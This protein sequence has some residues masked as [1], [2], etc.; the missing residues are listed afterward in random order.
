MKEKNIK[1]L[2]KEQ[3]NLIETPNVLSNIKNELGIDDEQIMSIPSNRK[4]YKTKL[5]LSFSMIIVFI[6]SIGV[7][8]L[9]TSDPMNDDRIVEALVVSSIASTEIVNQSVESLSDSKIFQVADQSLLSQTAEDDIKYEA[10]Y[11]T[12]YINMM[13]TL[14]DTK[15]NFSIEKSRTSTFSN[16]YMLSFSEDN[17]SEDNKNYQLIYETMSKSKQVY[18]VEGI[19]SYDSETYQ[20]KIIYDKSNQSLSYETYKDEQNYIRVTFGKQSEYAIYEVSRVVNDEVTESIEVKYKNRLNITLSFTKGEA[21]G[22]YS[23]EL[24]T[25]MFGR[26]YLDVSYSVNQYQG[27]MQIAVSLENRDEFVFVVTPEDGET[28]TF[29]QQRNRFGK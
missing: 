12:T 6:I 20:V 10:N 28:F 9:R 24:K 25:S 16:Q 21:H 7:V 29:N 1:K 18:T 26:K 19:L 17:L 8:R 13:A 3:A 11:L 22:S 15:Q 23:F 2:I 14:T 5:T 27:T 4:S